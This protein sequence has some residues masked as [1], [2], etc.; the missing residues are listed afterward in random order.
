MENSK[1]PLKKLFY[2]ILV[3]ISIP[4][5]Q[6]SLKLFSEK[7]LSG[8]IEKKLLVSMTGT[9]WFEGRY[10]HY[11]EAWLNDEFGF[12]SFFVR[13]NNQW[14]YLLFDKVHANSV[15]RGKQNYL[16]EYNYIKAYYGLDFV[17]RDSIYNRMQRAARIRDL[18]K[19]KGK[20]LLLVFAASK[21]QYFPEYFPDSIQYSRNETNYEHYLQA[22]DH[23]QL[24]YVDFNAFLLD[25]KDTS[26]HALYPKYGIHWSHYAACLVADSL[27]HTIELKLKKD[28]PDIW[29]RKIHK[30]PPEFDDNDIE[31][32]LNLLF[33]LRGPLYAYPQYQFEK[34]EG[35]YLPNVMVIA[36]S[37]YWSLF[38]L[39]IHK[40]FNRNPFWYYMFEVY[41]PG[42]V[43][44]KSGNSSFLARDLEACEI[45][46]VIS[47]DANLSR[48][49]WSFFET[50]EEIL[51][52]KSFKSKAFY[53]K[54]QNLV[55]YI[56]T[57]STWMKHIREKSIKLQIPVD[58]V[59]RM[60]AIWMVE[61]EMK[62][63]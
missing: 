20:E 50:A 4:W 9:N 54:V 58:S 19:S 35:K 36:D 23:F 57:D 17:G 56:P 5:L 13:L 61:E 41:E 53:E 30:A 2:A 22:C 38:N 46:V 8:G 60:D 10:Q 63:K 7:K 27:I 33:P 15:I 26:K 25:A 6:G 45:V 39:G 14:D 11:K 55:N 1:K 62:G 49:G 51:S 18:L 32:G 59:I 42:G 47:T 21:G 37:Y 44:M 34:P 24:D 16:F 28:L 48:L 3:L 12:R 40:S 31:K 52:D 43:E 29:W